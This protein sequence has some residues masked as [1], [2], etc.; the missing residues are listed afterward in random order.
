MDFEK[1]ILSDFG[2]KTVGFHEYPKTE[3]LQSSKTKVTYKMTPQIY[4]AIS[5]T[6]LELMTFRGNVVAESDTLYEVE[7]HLD[8]KKVKV[9][10]LYENGGI[11]GSVLDQQGATDREVKKLMDTFIEKLDC[12]TEQMEVDWEPHTSH[13]VVEIPMLI[14]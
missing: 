10:I 2:H 8:D 6:E 5:K 1:E 3:T 7:W 9:E 11:V 14:G 13:Q 12:D 4:N